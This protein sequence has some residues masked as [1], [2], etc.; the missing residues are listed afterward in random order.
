MKK[1]E[2]LTKYLLH[3]KEDNFAYWT[4]AKTTKEDSL[5]LSYPIYSDMV[6]QFINDVYK[7]EKLNP[8]MK[9][10][11][12]RKILEHN[13]IKNLEEVNLIDLDGQCIVA[14]IMCVIR[15]ERF[16]DGVIFYYFKH[17]IIEKWLQRLYEI[18]NL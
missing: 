10:N 13:N 7:F 18:D 9:L 15:Q 5:I 8:N 12:Y 14:M 1:Y 17:G 3:I 2:I 6:N 4:K 11:E 16:G